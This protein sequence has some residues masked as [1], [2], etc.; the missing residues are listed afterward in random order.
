MCV[1]VCVCVCARV[2]VCFS[3]NDYSCIARNGLIN[4]VQFCLPPTTI[5]DISQKQLTLSHSLSL[6]PLKNDLFLIE[7]K[8]QQN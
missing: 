6:S 1:C 3:H 5:L 4:L 7:M 8:I 2:C